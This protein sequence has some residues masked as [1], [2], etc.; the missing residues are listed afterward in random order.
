MQELVD[1]LLTARSSTVGAIEMDLDAHSTGNDCTFPSSISAVLL[2]ASTPFAL[3]NG[4]FSTDEVCPLSICH[5]LWGAKALG[6]QNEFIPLSCLIDTG[7]HIN[8]VRSDVV[9]RLGLTPLPLVKPLPVILAFDRSS[10]AKPFLLSTFVEFSLSSKNSSWSSCTCKAVIVPSL[11]ADFILRLPF[12]SFNK[13]VVDCH[14]RTVTHTPTNINLLDNNSFVKHN[15]CRKFTPL[16]KRHRAMARLHKNLL[17]ELKIVCEKQRQLYEN[18]PSTPPHSFLAVIRTRVESLTFLAKLK[19]HEDNARTLL[20]DVFKPVP[21]LNRLPISDPVM[22]IEFKD[23]KCFVQKHNYTV[24]KHYENAM[25][26]IL[27]LR[28]SQGFIR[29]SNSQFVLPSFIVPKSDPS[30]LPR[31]VCDYW[32]LNQNMLPDNYPMPGISD[33]LSNCG[34]GKIWSKIDLTDSYFQTRVHP[35]DIHKTAVSTPCGLFEWTVMPMGFRNSPAIQQRCLENALHGFIGRICHVYSDHIIIW[36][37][38]LQEHIKN[39]HVILA[40]LHKAGVFI[41]S[42][43]SVLFT[44]DM[45]FLGHRISLAGIEAC[46]RKAGKIIDW[47]VPTSATETRQFL[48]LVHYLHNFLPDL[49]THCRVLEQLTQKQFERDFPVWTQEHQN[50]FDAIKHLVVSHNC[51]TVIDPL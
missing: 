34:H 35:D 21:H 10:D 43:K 3:R 45:E 30:A 28:L 13:I 50:S 9:H 38:N 32:V 41:N 17:E 25:D 49:A 2:L 5:L 27:D 6:P 4:L 24:P 15:D 36:S 8:C 14:A 23:N 1:K 37:N 7:A 12:L 22:R 47:P 29:P 19:Q 46:D 20:A 44:T 39:V 18:V 31:W 40:A 48:G 42:K 16:S 33:I 51:L 11:C 26:K